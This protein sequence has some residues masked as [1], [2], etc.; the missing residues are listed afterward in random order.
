MQLAREFNSDYFP[1]GALGGNQQDPTLARPKIYKSELCYIDIEFIE[2]I[3]QELSAGRLVLDGVECNGRGD[4]V[5][6]S[7]RTRSVSV[8]AMFLIEV[9]NR[10]L[11]SYPV[12]KTQGMICDVV[13]TSQSRPLGPCRRHA[14]LNLPAQLTIKKRAEGSVEGSAW[15]NGD[16][17]GTTAWR[18]DRRVSSEIQIRQ[19]RAR[20]VY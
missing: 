19:K 7:D 16:K 12:N 11:M 9:I 13:T 18:S 10:R 15:E 17:C 8:G 1:K 5:E 4:H 14:Y 3:A 2:L 20:Y 6:T